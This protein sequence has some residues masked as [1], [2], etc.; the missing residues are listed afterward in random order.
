MQEIVSAAG[1]VVTAESALGAGTCMHVALR[2]DGPPAEPPGVEKPCGGM[3][4]LVEDEPVARRLAQRALMAWGWQEVSAESA[5]SAL[6]RGELGQ[7]AAVI[8][9][10][11]LP[12]YSGAALVAALRA[13]PGG[14]AL[15]AIIVSGHG[16]AMLRRDPVVQALLA[17][18][19]PPTVL[20]SKPYRLPE[21]RE[22]LAT[23]A[24]RRE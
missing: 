21:L 20:L 13:R 9:D 12:G 8:T 17:V 11:E 23:I 1:G 7:L 14:A 19:V 22:C 5:E 2:L 15:P 16:E 6:E 4:L 3:V 18:T 24:I 10:M